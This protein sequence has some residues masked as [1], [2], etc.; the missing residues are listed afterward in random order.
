M[1]DSPILF[2]RTIA[3]RFGGTVVLEDMNLTVER[4]SIHALV[5]ESGAGKSTLTKVLAG[6]VRPDRGVIEFDGKTA[7]IDSPNAARKLGI[8]VVLQQ[9][10]LFPER[11]VLANLFVNREPV[12]NGLISRREMEARSRDLLRQLGLAVDVHAPLRDLS[13]GDRQLV[14]ITR[15]LLENPRLLV[16]DD[17][18]SALDQH[19]SERLFAVLR[20]LKAR[21]MSMLYASN[22]VEDALAIADQLTVI[23]NGR[24]VLSKARQELTAS[25]EAMIGQ[26]RQSLFPLPLRALPTLAGTLRPQITVDGL[27]GGILSDVSF[28]ARAGEILGLNGSGAPDLLALLFG[29]RKARQGKVRFPDG[30][31]LPGTPTE[32]ARRNICMI[33]GDR[34]KG[35]MADKSIA[36]NMANV[37]VGAR[38]WGSRW[39]SP[40]AALGRAARQI[41][42]LRIRSTPQTPA[43]SLSAGGQQKVV[44]A[45]W[46]E[47]GP[48]VVLLDEPARG[49]DI[50]SK[51]EIYALIRQMAA[52]GCIVLLHSSELSELTGLCDRILAFHQG[53]LAG[54]IAGDDMDV[55]RLLKL[56]ISGKPADENRQTSRES[57]A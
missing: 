28:T 9:P 7:T 31:G 51:Q 14:A 6:I 24:D 44:I 22:R 4:G 33:S 19:Q 40:G 36:F 23:R 57:A 8:G 38:N 55:G 34:G 5:G 10:G 45:K 50:G 15:S 54:E 46:L 3:K 47:I 20:G 30:D 27:S 56:I 49:I 32:A 42:A 43:G 29:L 18:N 41:E 39:Y 13:P 53:R 35:L 48:Q 17:P 52:S 11:P 21:G 2:V 25:E 37:V 1:S 26:L 16:L 12:H